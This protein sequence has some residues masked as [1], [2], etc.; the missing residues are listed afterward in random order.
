LD[1]A[2]RGRTVALSPFDDLVSDR[3]RLER[4]FD[5]YHRIEI[6]VPKAKRQWGYF[7]LPVLRGD[8]IV[9]RVD[10]FFDRKANLLR[11]NAVHMQDG[12]S[13][14]D[15]AAVGRAIEDLRRWLRADEV[16]IAAPS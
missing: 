2:F 7:V 3:E 12:T 1:R 6:Y 5:M 4:L 11:I 15:R 8:R 13:A 16:V 9:G 14:A 10:P